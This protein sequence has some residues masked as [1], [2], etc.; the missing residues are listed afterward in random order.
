MSQAPFYTEFHPRWHR[1]KVSTYWWLHRRSY[2]AFILRELSSVFIAWFVV[3]TLLQVRAVKGGPAAYRAFEA[4][5]AHPLVIGVNVVSLF[6]IVF[7]AVTWFNLAPKAVVVHVGSRRLPGYWL[8]VA[9]YAAWV[10][11]SAGLV[12]FFFG[13]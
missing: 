3:F 5:A 8:A 1:T 10:A 13:G 4:F 11:V 6:F 7:H 12:W 9:N 2:L